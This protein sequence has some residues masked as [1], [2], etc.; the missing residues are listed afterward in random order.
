[1]V[2]KNEQR[3]VNRIVNYVQGLSTPVLKTILFLIWTLLLYLT[4]QIKE[5]QN[6]EGYNILDAILISSSFYI[7]GCGGIL[8][9]IRQELELPLGHKLRGT[10]AI[11]AGTIQ[12]ILGWGIAT[13]FLVLGL[14]E[15][16]N[17]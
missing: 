2:K 7:L 11:V 17:F 12:T 4:M 16:V 3:F 1:M 14:S 8:N 5:L 13:L 6:R 9:I 15:V 10:L